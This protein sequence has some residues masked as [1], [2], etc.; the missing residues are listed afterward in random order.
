MK[1]II[2]AAGQGTRLAP[3]T[4]TK[5]KCLVEL[6][7]IP[8]IEW[9]IS[10]ARKAGIKEIIVIR[11]Y[12]GDKL[13]Y[14]K[15]LDIKL[16]ENMEYETTNMVETLFK[17][18]EYL[19]GEVIISYGDIVYEESVINKLL[20][21]KNEIS[22]VVDHGWE[23]YWKKRV[24]NIFLDAESLMLDENNNIIGIGQTVESIEYI[25]GQYIGLSKFNN[26]GLEKLKKIY[27]K[28][29]VAF[30]KD[31]NYICKNRN[32]KQL[33]MTDILQGLINH[34]Y[35]VKEVAINRGWVEIDNVSDLKLAEQ[36]TSIINTKISI[37]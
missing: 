34:K 26:E 17:A 8:L 28:E 37:K 21:N 4:N 1:L 6:K 16:I 35:I 25:Q 31:T 24:D 27:I 23:N 7:G 32:L 19:E 3:L 14:L 22:V 5:P 9:Q 18:N 20:E 10:I 11:G 13:E 29:Q 2:L 36:L 30:R 33:Y 12:K 15:D